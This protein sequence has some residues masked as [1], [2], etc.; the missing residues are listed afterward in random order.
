MG[1]QVY[2]KE[3]DSWTY[4]NP[5]TGTTNHT[6]YWKLTLTEDNFDYVNNTSRVYYF[7]GVKNG[8]TATSWRAMRNNWICWG[9]DTD[10]TYDD[11]VNF[12]YDSSGVLHTTWQADCDFHRDKVYHMAC[13]CN[14]NNN[15][16]PLSGGTGSIDNWTSNGVHVSNGTAWRTINHN[17][18][19][20]ATCKFGIKWGR[21]SSNLFG[22]FSV[23]TI[24]TG[25][26]TLGN[27]RAS[28]KIYNGSA[29]VNAIPYVYD[30]S[31]WKQAIPYVYNG[32]TWV[33][34]T[35]A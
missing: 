10:G 25:T 5:S 31:A 16:V 13:W 33:N 26:V 23:K 8:S 19:G 1:V 15:Y 21:N 22:Y 14:D 34:C 24:E 35:G 11:E 3:G 6:M 9:F 2:N 7:F 32:S 20:S 30:G 12:R 27:T 4:R 28:V 29:W 18:D 17:S